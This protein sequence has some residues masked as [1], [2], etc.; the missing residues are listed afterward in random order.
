MRHRPDIDGLR[1]IAIVPVLL[2]HAGV[3]QVSGGFVGVDVFFVIS[4]YLISN[5]LLDDISKE[6]FS[7]LHFYERRVRRILPALFVLILC[8]CIAGYR[9]LTPGD[10]TTFGKSVLATMTFSSNIFFARQTGYFQQPA[11]NSPL[12][13]TWSL[14][15]EEQFYIFYPL[16]LFLVSRYFR[17][18]YAAALLPLFGVS[19]LYGI[20]LVAANQ[21]A[22]FYSAPARA[23]ELLLGGI[24]ALHIIPPLRNRLAANAAA[25]VGLLLLGYSFVRFSPSTSFPGMAALCPTMG[26]ALLIYSAE[27]S[28]PL[29]A[30]ILSTK[31]VAFI[32]LISYSLYL[33]H[34]VLLVFV[35][36]WLARSLGGWEVAGVIGASILIASLSWK[37]VENPFRGRGRIISSRRLLFAAA[38]LVSLAFASFGGLLYLRQGLPSRFDPQVLDLLARNYWTQKD[39]CEDRFCPVG[40]SAATPS[41]LLWGDSHAGALVPAFDSIAQANQMSGWIAYSSG[42]APLLGLKRYDQVDPE[43]C[44]RFNRFVVDQIAAK[45]IKTVFLHSRWAAY[46]EGNRGAGHP[47]FLTKDHIPEQDYAVFESLLRQ[48]VEQLELLHVNVVLIASVPEVW[49]D[50]PT[51]LARRAISG[52]GAEPE[53]PYAEFLHRQARVFKLFSEI[54]QRYAISVLYPDSI[55][56]RTSF[57]VVVNEKHALYIDDSHLSIKGAMYV[58]P[59]FTASL[60]N[61][62]SKGGFNHAKNDVQAMGIRTNETALR[63]Q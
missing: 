15:V 51:V 13:H 44:A 3:S 16:F 48:T 39:V 20:W 28:T 23:W 45:H 42:C 59:V 1:A 37:F 54:T 35:R 62:N 25:F 7:I 26:A 21:S 9:L 63:A 10:A 47:I 11:E 12:L 4:G 27:L 22:A 14:A 40:D 43:K 31:P 53:L 52:T 49:M 33:W 2:F 32:G 38:A 34:W 19:F 5:L 30:S 57:C 58:S 18:R 61:V 36:Y 6:R 56:C 41:F 24:L 17:R 8:A 29:V 50:V 60:R 46:C 55:L